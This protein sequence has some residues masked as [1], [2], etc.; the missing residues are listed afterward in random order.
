MATTPAAMIDAD[1]HEYSIG[2]TAIIGSDCWTPYGLNA[3]IVTGLDEGNAYRKDGH[4]RV[5]FD[6]H[7]GYHG[8]FVYLPQTTRKLRRETATNDPVTE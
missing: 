1:G 2:D 5:R 3:G 8:E 7:E 6:A 4:I